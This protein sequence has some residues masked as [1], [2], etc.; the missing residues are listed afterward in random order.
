MDKIP[1]ALKRIA[2]IRGDMQECRDLLLR[3]RAAALKL[4]AKA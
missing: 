1:K 2:A 3:I 4:P